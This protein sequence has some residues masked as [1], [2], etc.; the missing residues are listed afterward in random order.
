M[1]TELPRCLIVDWGGV[2]TSSIGDSWRSWARKEGLDV[3][4]FDEVL[5]EMLH[6]KPELGGEIA[7]NAAAR[8]HA[9]ERGEITDSEFEQYLTSRL[10]RIDGTPME[11]TGMLVT[12]MAA[13]AEAPDM[14]EVVRRAKWHGLR[15]ALLSNSWS[16]EAYDRT[17]WSD[18][19]DAAVISGEVGM[20]KPEPEI[21]LHT[22]SLVGVEPRQC[23]F[24][25][26]L[27]GNVRGA[28][29]VGM[30]GVHHV[31][32]ATTIEELTA[33]FGVEFAIT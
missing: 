7:N 33:L 31:N 30:I 24:V 12:M 18:M 32:V 25:D 3:T 4:Q 8:M 2:L 20:R 1:D 22:A 29:R 19:F 14:V 28:V 13:L 21:Y 11:G 6:A 26:D 23:V 9:F 27:E 5:R 10:R 15:T 17:G 16:C